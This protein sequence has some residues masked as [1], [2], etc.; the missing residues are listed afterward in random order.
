MCHLATC[1]RDSLNGEKK[2]VSENFENAVQ[3]E[4]GI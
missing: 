4:S 1:D 2:D 3:K